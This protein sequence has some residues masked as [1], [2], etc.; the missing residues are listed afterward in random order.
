VFNGLPQS[1]NA[2]ADTAPVIFELLF[3]GPRV[4]MPPPSRERSVPRLLS[5]AEG[6]QLRQFQPEAASLLRA[7]RAKMSR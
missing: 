7:R 1:P 6:S 2:V 5:A 4:P 3:A